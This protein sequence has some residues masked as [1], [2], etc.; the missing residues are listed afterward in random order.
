MLSARVATATAAEAPA[1]AVVRYAS[2]R[3][4]LSLYGPVHWLQCAVA[5]MGEVW[6]NNLL[7][8]SHA[9]RCRV[10]VLRG[11]GWQIFRDCRNK[12]GGAFG[13]RNYRKGNQIYVGLTI[14][15]DLS[16]GEVVA[17]WRRTVGV[18]AMEHG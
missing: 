15:I 6:R 16:G 4:V 2:S 14:L 9:C 10:R 17:L 8:L 5:Y 1:A 13:G 3:R 12:Q 7:L 11:C 18:P